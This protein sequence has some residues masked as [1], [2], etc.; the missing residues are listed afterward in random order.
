MSES[1]RLARLL[2]QNAMTPFDMYEVDRGNRTEVGAGTALAALVRFEGE[3]AL[4]KLH[5][6]A[7]ILASGLERSEG[8][9]A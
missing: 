6:Y 2:E 1:Q 3:E 9:D 7:A 5:A 4:N 8:G